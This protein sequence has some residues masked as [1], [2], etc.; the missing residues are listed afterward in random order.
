MRDRQRP[1][2]QVA[3]DRVVALDVVE[4][5]RIHVGRAV[6]RQDLAD[7]V[8]LPRL[9]RAVDQQLEERLADPDGRIASPCKSSSPAA[10]TCFRLSTV[11]ISGLVC[12]H[13]S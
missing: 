4:D 10:K 6:V 2:Q 3:A 12:R 1:G 9:D 8:H 13:W 7:D 5:G 11:A